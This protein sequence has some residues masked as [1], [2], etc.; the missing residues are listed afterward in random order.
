MSISAFAALR[1]TA[2]HALIPPGPSERMFRFGPSFW[3]VGILAFEEQKIVE[4]I[5]GFRIF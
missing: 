1:Q 3:Q 4:A 5:E 2:L